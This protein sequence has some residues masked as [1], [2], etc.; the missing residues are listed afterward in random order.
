MHNSPYFPRKAEDKLFIYCFFTSYFTECYCC[1]PSNITSFISKGHDQRVYCFLTSYSCKCF[2]CCPSNT[3]ISICEGLDQRVYC[4]LTSYSP[5][6]F[7]CDP[8]NSTIFISKGLDQR[9]YCFLTSYFT[10]YICSTLSNKA[11]D[12]L[13]A[14]FG[15]RETKDCQN[16]VFIAMKLF[17]LDLPLEYKG[18]GR[19][20]VECLDL[21]CIISN[22]R[23]YKSIILT[24][25]VY[26][27]IYPH[28][29][30]NELIFSDA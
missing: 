4:F 23:L 29:I 26:D 16:A 15:T 14:G 13:I 9:D 10:K 7:C 19:L 18:M 12:S 24:H 27:S 21:Y 11:V 20:G 8:S 1:P 5:K 25:F 3:T 22:L 17:N 30:N 2:Y 6:C 28:S